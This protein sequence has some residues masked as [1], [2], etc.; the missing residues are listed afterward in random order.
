MDKTAHCKKCGAQ[1]V[2][3]QIDQLGYDDKGEPVYDHQW[4]YC[5]SSLLGR[6]SPVWSHHFGGHSAAQFKIWKDGSHGF[7]YY[8]PSESW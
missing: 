8:E 6:F 3:G 5:P 7:W 2:A 4:F 1:L